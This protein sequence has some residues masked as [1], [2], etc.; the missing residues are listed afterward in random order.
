MSC[1]TEDPRDSTLSNGAPVLVSPLSPN[2]S[3]WQAHNQNHR[4]PKHSRPTTHDPE[5]LRHKEA[6]ALEVRGREASAR[7]AEAK[8]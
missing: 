6:S 5:R 7:E 8:Q 4:D 1:R 3:D 2:P